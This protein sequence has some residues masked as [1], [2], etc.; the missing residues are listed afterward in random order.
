MTNTKQRINELC[1]KYTKPLYTKD[2]L[3]SLTYATV[4]GSYNPTEKKQVIKAYN[5][6]GRFAD[7]KLGVHAPNGLTGVWFDEVKQ[8]VDKGVID[9]GWTKKLNGRLVDTDT[10]CDKVWVSDNVKDSIIL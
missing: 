7:T 4:Y 1:E 3:V 8:F 9:W 6:F 10:E 2:F 5:E